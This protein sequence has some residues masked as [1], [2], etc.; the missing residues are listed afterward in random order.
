M[1]TP[2][3]IA[4]KL[5]GERK[6]QL[7]KWRNFIL[8]FLNSYS[9]ALT[10]KLGFPSCV[11]KGCKS[12]WYNLFLGAITLFQWKCWI[13]ATFSPIIFILLH[14]FSCLRKIKHLFSSDFILLTHKH[15]LYIRGFISHFLHQITLHKKR[16]PLIL[17]EIS[18]YKL[19]FKIQFYCHIF[20]SPL[21]FIS[22]REAMSSFE[23]KKINL[24][25]RLTLLL[26]IQT[27][28]QL[29]VQVFHI[30]QKVKNQ[31]VLDCVYLFLYLC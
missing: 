20:Q 4:Y 2:K 25:L 9:C 12:K 24:F 28:H 16:K 29:F 5:F 17:S 31:T 13:Y 7:K 18:L 23:N 8:K 30:E 21:T 27:L 1:G 14:L 3:S 10:N 19:F 15:L 22:K 26:F 6:S 11:L